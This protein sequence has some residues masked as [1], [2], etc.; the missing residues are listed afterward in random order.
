[1]KL[2]NFKPRLSLLVCN[3]WR[4]HSCKLQAV[5]SFHSDVAKANDKPL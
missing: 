3:D 1:M 2:D 4:K 5:T